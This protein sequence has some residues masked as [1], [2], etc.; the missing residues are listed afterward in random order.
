MM[1]TW[2]TWQKARDAGSGRTTLPQEVNGLQ[3]HMILHHDLDGYTAFATRVH[4][5]AHSHGMDHEP[6]LRS[7]GTV[8]PYRHFVR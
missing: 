1:R 5:L 6:M 7:D 3:A 8:T 4:D 2:P